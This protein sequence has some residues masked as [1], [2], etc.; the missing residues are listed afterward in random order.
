MRKGIFTIE[1]SMSYDELFPLIKERAPW[2]SEVIFSNGINTKDFET[3]QPFNRHPL[4][5]L[6]IVKEY[7]DNINFQPRSVL[8]IGFNY[9]YNSI[10]LYQA[11]KCEVVGI[12]VSESHLKIA[13]FLANLASIS[14]LKFNIED[15]TYF[16]KQNYFDF[17]LH[18]GTLYHLPNPLLA[19]ENCYKN[20]KSGGI[21]ALETT[22]FYGENQ[23]SCK[24][25][26]GFKGDT[27]NF[28]ALSKKTIEYCLNF[29]GF[30]NIKLLKEVST[31]YIGND[32]SRVIYVAH[33]P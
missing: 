20:L 18:F 15:A 30:T 11:Y 29:Y 6:E 5:K 3:C 27:T 33:K 31:E 19:I 32:L 26:N 24:F 13:T 23:Y 14:D 28:W 10:G 1:T 4:L 21:L 2:R 9:G 16:V 25:I 17:I 7:L 12:D 8:D 22:A